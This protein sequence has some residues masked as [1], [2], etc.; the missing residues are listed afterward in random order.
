VRL[1]GRQ[2]STLFLVLGVLTWV[3]FHLLGTAY[4]GF[5]LGLG[6]LL[7]PEPRYLQFLM[8][9]ALYGSVGVLLITSGVLGLTTDRPR[10]RGWDQ[11]NFLI[12]AG[13]LGLLIPV[14]LRL[15]VLGG[16]AIAD[17]ESLYRF[18][19]SLLASGRLSA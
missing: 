10:W 11:R 4:Q 19:A 12:V 1:Q 7:E 3:V 16:A 15:T 17:D 13:A 14:A 2:R 8:Y 18:S 5:A 9:V 6:S